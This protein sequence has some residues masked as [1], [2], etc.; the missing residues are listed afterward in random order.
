M[1]VLVYTDVVSWEMHIATAVEIIKRHIEKGD[2]VF[3]V[4]HEIN[5]LGCIPHKIPFCKHCAKQSNFIFEK[6]FKKKIFKIDLKLQK[7][8]DQP[9]FLSIEKILEYR[10]EEMPIGELVMSSITDENRQ[11]FNDLDSIHNKIS[12]LINIGINLYKEICE[13]IDKQNIGIVY[14]WNGRRATTGPVLYAGLKKNIKFYSYMTGGTLN[15]YTVQP[16]TMVHDLKY[17]KKR[18]KELYEK[19]YE[20]GDTLKKDFFISEAKNFFNYFRYGVG[21]TWGYVYYKDLFDDKIPFKKISKKKILTIFTSSYYEFYALGIGFR[22]K[23]GKDINHYEFIK[24]ILTSP[25][26]LENYDIKVRWH[27]NLSFAG[28]VEIAEIE[29]IIQNTKKEIT[30]YSPF[31]KMNSYKLLENS[32][33]IISFGSTIGIEATYYG[34]ASILWGAAFYEDSGGVYEVNSLPELEKLLSKSLQPK[35]KINSMKYAFFER[36]KGEYSYEYIKY[37]KNDKYYFNNIRV[38]KPTFSQL[39]K[40]N[41]KIILKFFGMVGFGRKIYYHISKFLRLK[42]SGYT[43]LDW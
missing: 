9:K 28:K 32:D 23:N 15:T 5:E 19:Y 3:F 39:I 43:P 30:H 37:D 14:S 29:K 20:K 24:Q 41:V 1:N 2:K 12:S 7:K 40:E 10:H 4:T 21:K 25:Y 22:K 16:T 42:Y 38:Y 17:G 36:N 6:I 31:H 34:K 35:A 26:I 13:L 8:F 11:I 27:P 18:L 33:I